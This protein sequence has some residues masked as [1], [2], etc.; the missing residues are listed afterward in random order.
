MILFT[1]KKQY[2]KDDLQQMTDKHNVTIVNVCINNKPGNSL[3][4]LSPFTKFPGSIHV[5]GYKTVSV[6]S[7]WQG[8]KIFKDKS[9]VDLD[10]V[11][12][13]KNFRNIKGKKPLGHK[14]GET[15]YTTP[16]SARRAVYI[17]A[18]NALLQHPLALP[19][20]KLLEI[21]AIHAENV[22][23][24]LVL[25]DWDVSGNID[26]ERP[27]AHA[28]LLVALLNIRLGLYT[29]WSQFLGN[30]ISL[31]GIQLFD[32]IDQKFVDVNYHFDIQK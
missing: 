14:V 7:I 30:S 19:G 16:G 1:S 22:G 12:G 5:L 9:E 29:K 3:T 21:Y 15:L 6:D 10:V 20:F 8:L 25:L 26:D 13:R 32:P 24:D 28:A 23:K 11:E 27:F 17:P 4:Y 2:S 18:Y 31:T